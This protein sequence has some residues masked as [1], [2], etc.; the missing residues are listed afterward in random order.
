MRKASYYKKQSSFFESLKEKVNRYIPGNNICYPGKSQH[1]PKITYI[2]Y[3]SLFKAI[4]SHLPHVIRAE[5][6]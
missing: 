2:E 3:T 5:R 1:Y 6:L 4:H